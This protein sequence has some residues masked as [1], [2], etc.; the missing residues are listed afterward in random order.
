LASAEIEDADFWAATATLL[1]TEEAADPTL[2]A[3]DEK[4]EETPEAVEAVFRVATGLVVGTIAGRDSDSGMTS[5]RTDDAEPTTASDALGTM[6]EE[7]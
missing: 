6:V 5:G 7:E 3:A 2:E 1:T 4:A